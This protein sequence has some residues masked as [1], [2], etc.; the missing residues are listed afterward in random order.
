MVKKL[1]KYAI[2]NSKKAFTLI[3]LV[4]VIAVLAVVAA[5]A[6]P[7]IMGI[8]ASATSASGEEQARMLNEK[9]KTM[10]SEIRLGT[11]NNT[12]SK[13]ADGSAVNYAEAKN[14]SL[15]DRVAAADNAT[16][17]NVKSYNGL[18]SI[19][20]NDFYYCNNT[21]GSSKYSVGTI[22]YS[23]DGS[24]PDSVGCSFI[25]TNDNLTLGYLY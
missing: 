14:A 11:I 21:S 8:M 2:K 20:C 9:C 4:V 10:Y 22:Y 5:I 1:K 3:E 13:N 25:K 19:N 12:D 18:N 15:G 17:A 24:F 23:E 6:V 7:M 16:I